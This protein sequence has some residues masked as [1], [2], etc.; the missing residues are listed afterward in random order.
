M[1]FLA[2]I[3]SLASPLPT[4]EKDKTQYRIANKTLLHYVHTSNDFLDAHRKEQ[5]T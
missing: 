4:S 2:S 3:M 1:P 5:D